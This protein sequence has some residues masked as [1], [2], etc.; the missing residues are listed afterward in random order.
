MKLLLFDLHCFIANFVIIMNKTSVIRCSL[1][2]QL[3]LV[4]DFNV[5]DKVITVACPNLFK[6]SSCCKCVSLPISMTV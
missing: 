1:I 6:Y 2:K 3:D 4:Y 5:D